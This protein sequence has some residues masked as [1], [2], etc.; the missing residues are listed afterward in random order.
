MTGVFV[1]EIAPGV[2]ETHLSST[3][4]EDVAFRNQYDDG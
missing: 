1:L 2:E 3:W 4:I